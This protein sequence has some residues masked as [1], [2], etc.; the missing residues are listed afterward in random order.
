MRVKTKLLLGLILLATVPMLVSISIATWVAGDSSNTLLV[1][2]TQETLV[3]IRDAR[4]R[5]L[6]TRFD[7][8]SQ[9]ITRFS[10]KPMVLNAMM[11]LEEGFVDYADEV[12]KLS[13][14][15]AQPQLA[16]YYRQLVPQRENLFTPD[17]AKLSDSAILIQYNYIVKNEFAIGEKQKLDMVVEATLYSQTHADVHPQFVQYLKENKIYDIYLVSPKPGRL[18]TRSKKRPISV[19]FLPTTGSHAVKSASPTRLS[20]LQK[21]RILSIFQTS[22]PMPHQKNSSRC[23]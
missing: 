9:Q 12:T 13:V 10:R 8:I 17:I 1:A 6:E 2:K 15:E 22:H 4:K 7:R 16:K 23:L 11:D 5:Q 20:R 3:R 18:F 21:I 19:L 14:D